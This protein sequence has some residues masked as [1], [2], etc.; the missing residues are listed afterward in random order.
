MHERSIGGFFCA[1]DQKRE[2]IDTLA[3]EHYILPIE[4]NYSGHVY[5]G[6]Y[7]LP[8]AA[9][10]GEYNLVHHQ[11]TKLLNYR[12]RRLLSNFISQRR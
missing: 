4:T 11:V 6:E 12:T 5:W 3:H 1:D 2:R 8:F 10:L 9:C 7:P